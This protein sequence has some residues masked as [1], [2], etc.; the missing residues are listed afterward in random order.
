M[1][2]LFLAVA[3]LGATATTSLA[4]GVFPPPPTA[5]ESQA[6][7]QSLIAKTTDLETQLNKKNTAKAEE[8]AAQ[9]LNL[10]KKRVAQTRYMAEANTGAQR[11][12]LMKRMLMLENRVL[13]FRNAA[14]DVNANA[15]QLVA[16]AKTFSG[17]Y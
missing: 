15:Q 14:K 2:H 17:D 16:E 5:A 4:Q 8:A 1:K 6:G 9:I 11:D 13:S 7:K 12:A 10:M 3:L